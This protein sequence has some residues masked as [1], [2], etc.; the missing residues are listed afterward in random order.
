VVRAYRP[1]ARIALG[2][3]KLPI[4]GTIRFF[5]SIVFKNLKFSSDAK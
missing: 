3:A 2:P 4:T 5:S 1:T